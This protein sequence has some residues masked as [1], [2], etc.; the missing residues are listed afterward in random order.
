MN[1]T[2]YLMKRNNMAFTLVELLVVVA[3]IAL[4]AALLL[5]ALNRAKQ[6]TYNIR[7]VNNVRTLHV[8][9]MLYVDDTSGFFPV[10]NPAGGTPSYDYGGWIQQLAPYVHV[11]TNN[12]PTTSAFYCPIKATGVWA[13]PNAK[14]TYAMNH[15]LRENCAAADPCYGLGT[16]P[17]NISQFNNPS[18]TL[19]ITEN[20]AYG[21]AL[22]CYFLEY[23]LYGYPG[24]PSLASAAHGG[25]GIPFVYLDGHA[26]FWATVPPYNTYA[27]DPNLPWTH[28]VFWGGPAAR[29]AASNAPYNP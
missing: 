28:S 20:G 4:L 10:A 26:I 2:G 24:D 18:A 17:S 6:T 22:H 14:W 9:L 16:N 27:S 29:W 1:D 11:A 25:K 12:I 8:A 3:I 15:D 21:D 23:G 13:S 7:C 19:A 5:P